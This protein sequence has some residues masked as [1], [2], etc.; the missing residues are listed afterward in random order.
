MKKL[1]ILIILFVGLPTTLNSAPPPPRKHTINQIFESQNEFPADVK[2]S[3][4]SVISIKV[5]DKLRVIESNGIPNHKVGKFP[6][7]GNPHSI[8]PQK[9][10]FKIPLHPQ[11]ANETTSIE[12]PRFNFGIALS[13]VL[14]DPLARE[15]YLGDLKSDWRYEATSGAIKLGLDTNNAHVQPDGSYH[16]H[17]LPRGLENQIEEKF[18]NL[19]SPLLGWAADGFPIYGATGYSGDKNLIINKSSY[20]IKKGKRQNGILNPGGIY[21][22]TFINDFYYD[23]NYGTLDQCN[24][25]FSIT[26]EFPDGIYAYFITKE[27]PSI[28]RCFKGTPSKDFLKKK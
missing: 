14:F 28:P 9:Y 20:R 24:G 23:N 26:P 21:D 12:N 1:L 18:D 13:G 3:F 19:H 5:I 15:Y 22:G 7:E 16:Y 25:R 2:L 4:P 27:Y 6:N 10:K 11:I 17:A 8:K